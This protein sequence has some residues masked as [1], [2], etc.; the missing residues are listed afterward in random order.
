MMPKD[1]AESKADSNRFLSSQCRIGSRSFNVEIL[2][3]NNGGFVDISEGH[4]ARIGA[5]SVCVKTNQGVVSTNL[6]PDRRGG[7]FAQM[8]GELV[9]E[10]TS[11]MAIVSLYIKEEIDPNITKTLLNEVRTLSGKKD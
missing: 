2:K 7:I 10:R 6:V 3:F 8:V 5:I 4:D 9:A 1:T 11:G